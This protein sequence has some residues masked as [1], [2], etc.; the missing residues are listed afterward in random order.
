MTSAAS[1]QRRATVVADLPLALLVAVLQVI[2]SGVSLQDDWQ[3]AVSGGQAQR[4]LPDA[5]GLFLLLGGSLPLAFRRVAPLPV[6]LVSAAASIAY[7]ASGHRPEPLPL[8]V[9]VAL[10]TMAVALRP[11]VCNAAAGAYVL[12][13]TVGTL[14]GWLPL[15]DDQYYIDLVLLVAT[16]MLG[17]GIALSRAR[18][19]LAEQQAAA[20]TRDLDVRTRAAV[21]KEQARIAREVHDI[22]A[23]DVSVIVAQASSA[24]RVF[25]AQPKTA[26]DALASIEAVGR[27]ALDGLRRLF[28]LL[29]THSAESDRSPQPSLDRLPWLL[30]QVERAGL[31]VDLTIRGKPAALS[32]TVELN[33]FRIVQEALTNSLKHAG[34][35]RATV[36][37]DYEDEALAVEVRDEGSPQPT[38][39]R[40][41][42][43]GLISMQ[44]RVTMLGGELV[45][46]PETERGFRVSARL[47]LVG[48]PP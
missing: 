37:L 19:T 30:A 6:F 12:T 29:R 35:T 15:T 48:S 26:A 13:M 22:V 40:S 9:L 4:W 2:G 47:P 10:Y 34:P 14:T 31:P 1:S 45:A 27:D 41:P 46:G 24:R 23:H 42:G 20:M 21:E 33:A 38:S 11:A 44:Q 5:A 18:A 25:A 39:R 43:Y 28:G 16:V 7:H 17:Y 36:V 3:L 32:A 8:G